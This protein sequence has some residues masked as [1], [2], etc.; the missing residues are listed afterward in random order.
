MAQDPKS[1]KVPDTSV[2]ESEG[3]DTSVVVAKPAKRATGRA[4]HSASSNSVGRSSQGVSAKGKPEKSESKFENKFEN[5]PESK[6]ET[7][8][9]R[10]PEKKQISRVREARIERMMS[11]AELAR[12]AGLSVLTIDRV[13]KGLGCRMDTKRKILESLGLSLV[14]RKRVFGEEE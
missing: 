4:H 2:P 8:S 9:D 5:K 11:K 3:D 13:E 7:K 12:R 14:D 6:P 10:K 1:R